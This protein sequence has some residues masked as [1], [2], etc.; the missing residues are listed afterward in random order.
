MSALC[1]GND[2]INFPG[3]EYWNLEISF[4]TGPA[5]REVWTN[6]EIRDMGASGMGRGVAS[7]GV[8][9]LMAGWLVLDTLWAAPWCAICTR[10]RKK[11][12]A[13]S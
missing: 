13:A 9:G 2:S 8:G 7:T 10:Q 4:I 5:V 12:R 1:L 3:A 6:R 11:A